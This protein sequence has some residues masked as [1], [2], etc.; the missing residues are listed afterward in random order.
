MLSCFSK[1]C[2]C[3][4][5]PRSKSLKKTRNMNWIRTSGPSKQDKR[6]RK[7]EGIHLQSESILDQSFGQLGQSPPPSGFVPPFNSNLST[8]SVAPRSTS[9]PPSPSLQRVHH[10]KANSLSGSTD[11]DATLHPNGTLGST[12]DDPDSGMLDLLCP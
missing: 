1:A 4:I 11:L 9:P 3:G 5:K 7:R 8:R 12:L 6:V 2:R 10:H